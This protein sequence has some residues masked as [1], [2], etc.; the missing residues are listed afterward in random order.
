M[1]SVSERMRKRPSRYAAPVTKS[2]EECVTCEQGVKEKRKKRNRPETT[3]KPP[4]AENMRREKKNGKEK[5][6]KE[7]KKGKRKGNM[8][9]RRK[10]N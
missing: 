9:Q 3:P 10:K 5:N 1:W 4:L 7:I 8:K 6:E 2:T